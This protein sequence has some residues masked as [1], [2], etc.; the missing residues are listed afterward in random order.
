[1]Q[2]GAFS[3]D[4]RNF[5]LNGERRRSLVEVMY[6]KLYIVLLHVFSNNSQTW[7]HLLV[8]WMAKLEYLPGENTWNLSIF[9]KAFIKSC[10]DLKIS[11]VYKKSFSV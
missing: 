8:V 7:L 5:E 1:M 3:F 4:K 11:S 2:H 10:S 9:I 6:S